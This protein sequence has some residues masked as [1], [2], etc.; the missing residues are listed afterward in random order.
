MEKSLLPSCRNF[1]AEFLLTNQ[2]WPVFSSIWGPD[3]SLWMLPSHEPLQW[4]WI[5]HSGLSAQTSR[6][7]QIMSWHCPGHPSHVPGCR[8]ASLAL[9]SHIPFARAQRA[10]ISCLLKREWNTQR[11]KQRTFGGKKRMK[12]ALNA[13][14]GRMAT[15]KMERG[16]LQ[17]TFFALRKQVYIGY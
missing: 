17:F 7:C 2:H 13:F 6:Q 4:I 10:G 5:T 14:S 3:V 9:G 8:Q 11:S 1:W 15:R 16:F 12:K